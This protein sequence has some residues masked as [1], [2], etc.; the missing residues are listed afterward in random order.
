MAAHL[1][2]ASSLAEMRHSR[3]EVDQLVYVSVPGESA[4][5]LNVSEG[6]IAIQAMDIMKPGQSLP[7][8]FPL[9]DTD[10]EVRGMATIVWSDRSGRA[11]LRFIEIGEFDRFQLQWWLK[12]A[13]S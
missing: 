10:I 3:V 8:A 11:G 12:R 5:M 2:A 13:A 9:P 4:F 6:G 1:N 7:F